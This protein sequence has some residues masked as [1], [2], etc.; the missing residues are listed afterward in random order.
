M[1]REI[2]RLFKHC[3]PEI[4]IQISELLRGTNKIEYRAIMQATLKGIAV[5]LRNRR[6]YPDRFFPDHDNIAEDWL[7]IPYED[8]HQVTLVIPVTLEQK[9]VGSQR[10][11]R[12][13]ITTITTPNEPPWWYYPGKTGLRDQFE[14]VKKVSYA[15]V[16]TLK[17]IETKV[18]E[19][20][21]KGIH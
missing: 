16:K 2:A 21:H 11:A 20:D 10:T 8:A 18:T 17:M 19:I 13:W 7:K 15:M 3:E 14:M 6:Q 9:I 12:Y 1:S 4:D 5:G